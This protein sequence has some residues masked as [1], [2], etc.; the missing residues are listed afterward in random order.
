MS[1][2]EILVR[3]AGAT[4]GASEVP[5]DSNAGPFVER[6]LRITGLGAG[7]PWC[8]AFVAMCG[9]ETF[10]P[11]WPLPKT[12]S[13]AAL[14]TFAQEKG[15]LEVAPAVGDVF[16]LHFPKLGR[17]AHTGF[18]V[19]VDAGQI[20]TIEGNTNAGGGREGW[21]VARRTRKPGAEDRFVRWITLFEGDR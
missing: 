12:A 5:A 10:G 15:V 9:L 3:V 7:H 1:P 6:C 17:F 13:C 11:L 2:I 21:L 8:A 19:G 20:L 16:L 4:V 18:V 14:G